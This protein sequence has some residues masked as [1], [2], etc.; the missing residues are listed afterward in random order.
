MLRKQ[1][2]HGREKVDGDSFRELHD[3]HVR[4]EDLSCSPLEE[5]RGAHTDVLTW[6]T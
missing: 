6:A 3:L 4:E 1:R 5:V 2:E